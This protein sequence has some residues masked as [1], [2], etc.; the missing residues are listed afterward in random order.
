[1]SRRKKTY[2]KR[3]ERNIV[4]RPEPFPIRN[5]ANN[6]LRTL[7]SY[8]DYSVPTEQQCRWDNCHDKAEH[9]GYCF[10]HYRQNQQ[11]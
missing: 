6:P 4:P 11:Y 7:G 3:S 8:V 2:K 5:Y 9:D 10:E 1:M